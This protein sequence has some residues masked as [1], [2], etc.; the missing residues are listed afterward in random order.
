MLG[1]LPQW[2][3]GDDPQ[4]VDWAGSKFA[5]TTM[6]QVLGTRDSLLPL[7][8]GPLI[9]DDRRFV[10]ET[11]VAVNVEVTNTYEGFPI[12]SNPVRRETFLPKV[13]EYFW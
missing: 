13:I 12:S 10:Y 6:G 2:K 7:K 1:V 9:A 5:D 3:E 4:S 8:C 11:T